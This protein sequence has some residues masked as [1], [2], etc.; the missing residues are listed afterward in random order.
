M[1][2]FCQVLPP[3]ISLQFSLFVQNPAWGICSCVT[4]AFVSLS[5]P[6]RLFLTLV[7]VI[8]LVSGSFWICN[9]YSH[10]FTSAANRTV[11]SGLAKGCEHKHGEKWWQKP[12]SLNSTF[13]EISTMVFLQESHKSECII[14]AV[15][16]TNCLECSFGCVVIVWRLFK[17]KVKSCHFW[18]PS[19]ALVTL[20]SSTTAFPFPKARAFKYCFTVLL[21]ESIFLI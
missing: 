21:P 18:H 4:I 2:S 3:S 5:T 1:F 6:V 13:S 19:L 10:L 16:W 11:S 15:K 9:S 7:L 20:T 12:Q 17:T 8:L 14:H